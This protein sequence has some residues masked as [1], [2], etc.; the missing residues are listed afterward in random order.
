[1]KTSDIHPV[2]QYAV[3]GKATARVKV[4]GKPGR[5]RVGEAKRVLPGAQVIDA[6]A[7]PAD[8]ENGDELPWSGGG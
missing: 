1:M 3:L 8:S 2:Q 7:R 5:V 4:A 6:R